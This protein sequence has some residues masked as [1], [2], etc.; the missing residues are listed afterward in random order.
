MHYK[1]GQE[2]KVGDVIKGKGYNLKDKD[3]NLREV[4]GVVI[5]LVPGASTCNCT[6]SVSEIVDRVPLVD[7]KF[8]DHRYYDA[9]PSHGMQLTQVSDDKGGYMAVLKHVFE[10]G[11]CDHFELVH[12]P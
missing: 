2:A 3:G 9:H 4:V 1:D 7:W 10:Y 6:I 5:G 8:P 11:Q 12:R